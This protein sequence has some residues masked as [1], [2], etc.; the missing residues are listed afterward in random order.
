M[1]TEHSCHKF[2]EG[3]ER[4]N[5]LEEQVLDHINS[6]FNKQI[7]ISGL[8]KK[9]HTNRTTLSRKF[10]ALT[11]STID[12]YIIDKRISMAKYD[13]DST[14]LNIYVISKSCGFGDGRYTYFSTMFKK[15]V[16][17]SPRKYRNEMRNRRPK[18][19]KKIY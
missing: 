17:M 3:G 19:E 2:M 5:S 11:N 4:V 12:D 7:T 16:G 18:E 15:R 10:K 14:S 6:N 8:C 1:I 13:L 9:F